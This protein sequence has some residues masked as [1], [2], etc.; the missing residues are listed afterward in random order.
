VAKYIS[1]PAR[2]AN[3]VRLQRVAADQ[4]FDPAARDQAFLAG[5][6]QQ[7]TRHQHADQ[8][9]R[10]DLLGESPALFDPLAG[11]VGSAV[12]AE[13]IATRPATATVKGSMAS[14]GRPRS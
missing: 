5:P 13:E 3:E 8:Q 9:Q 7:E 11:L 6:A 1:E 4:L 12:P 14:Q 2:A 10:G